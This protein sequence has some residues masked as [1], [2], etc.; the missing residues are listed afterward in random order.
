MNEENARPE[1]PNQ[2]REL[3]SESYGKI[4]ERASRSPGR[5]P[6]GAA[7]LTICSRHGSA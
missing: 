5:V 4:A 7:K 3:V 6:P 1:D 2:L